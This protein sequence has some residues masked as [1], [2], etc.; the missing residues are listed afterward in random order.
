[1]E[2]RKG[3]LKQSLS[4]QT[5]KT[6]NEK[7][8]AMFRILF[9]VAALSL[10]FSGVAEAKGTSRSGHRSS[11]RS[12]K[13][14]SHRSYRS[15]HAKVNKVSHRS[16]KT[17]KSYSK[18]VAYKG[19]KGYNKRVNYKGYRTYNTKRVGYG[20]KG[21]GRKFKYG[22]YYQG[23]QHRHWSKW[24]Y[25]S[26]YKCP[27]YWCGSTSAWYYWCAPKACYYPVSYVSYAAP[28]PCEA[29]TDLDDSCQQVD[30]PYGDDQGG[31]EE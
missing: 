18:P 1:V 7:E 28:T 23:K 25:S 10:A 27:I 14:S 2:R 29:P 6:S 20:Y 19:Y 17:H 31:E 8:I 5:S 3:W 21:Y 4:P 13:V 24:Y 26:T 15:S 9:S 22:Y 16:Y 12:H 11:V 30:E